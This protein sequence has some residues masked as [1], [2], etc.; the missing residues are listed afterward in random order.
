M[1]LIAT[2]PEDLELEAQLAA[3]EQAQ[4]RL[5]EARLRERE[6]EI[7]EGDIGLD[8]QAA[9]KTRDSERSPCG[10]RSAAEARRVKNP[11]AP[12]QA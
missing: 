11:M 1:I 6:A 9:M 12:K 2:S 10:H 4:T 3:A 8:T 5:L 7:A